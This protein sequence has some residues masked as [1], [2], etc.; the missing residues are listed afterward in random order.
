MFIQICNLHIS[1]IFFPYSI[2]LYY[3]RRVFKSELHLAGLICRSFSILCFLLRFDMKNLEFQSLFRWICNENY[4]KPSEFMT[5]VKQNFA[6]REK[7]KGELRVTTFNLTALPVPREFDREHVRRVIRASL[8]GVTYVVNY[9]RVREAFYI[10]FG[11]RNILLN[12]YWRKLSAEQLASMKNKYLADSFLSD[13]A[14]GASRI[15]N[16][17]LVS[18]CST[19]EAK[20]DRTR[21]LIFSKHYSQNII[22]D[23]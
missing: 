12:C 20:S 15:K 21:A 14:C 11:D 22:Q 7:M 19:S 4:R 13:L 5:V 16:I 6:R 1:I 8:S 3:Y 18:Y 17:Y 2:C 9:P 10:A 23:I